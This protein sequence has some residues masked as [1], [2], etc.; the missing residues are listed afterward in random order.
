VPLL[1]AQKILQVPQ[2]CVLAFHRD[3]PPQRL[4]R[5]NWLE[6]QPLID[7]HG[8]TMRIDTRAAMGADA[9]AHR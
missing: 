8:L 9:A 5:A 1:S 7:R 4:R 6:H 3:L 2:E